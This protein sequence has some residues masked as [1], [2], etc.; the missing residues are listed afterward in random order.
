MSSHDVLTQ[1]VTFIFIHATVDVQPATVEVGV[2][3]DFAGTAEVGVNTDVAA[4]DEVRVNTDVAATIDVHGGV[5]TDVGV[6]EES[7]VDIQDD[8]SDRMDAVSDDATVTSV[9]E[10][11]QPAPLDTTP[12]KGE[13]LLRRTSPRKRPAGEAFEAD[14]QKEETQGEVPPTPPTKRSLGPRRGRRARK[15]KML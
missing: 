8:S 15:P 13:S 12:T 14:S 4:T 7:D 5:N 1:H 2:N 10:D 11:S 3:T 9:V 6:T